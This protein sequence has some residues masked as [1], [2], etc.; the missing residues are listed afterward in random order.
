MRP[1]HV[2]FDWSGT[3][4]DDLPPVLEATNAVLR[5]AGRSAMDRETFRREFRLPYTDFYAEHTPH[6]PLPELEGV[7]RQAFA[8][9]QA[10][11]TLLPHAERFLAASASRGGRH[12][13]LSS[14]PQAA[15]E[16]QARDLG[17]YDYFEAF[18]ASVI[19]KRQRIHSL[20][21]ELGWHPAA[22]LYVGDMVHDAHTARQAGIPFAAVL[23]GYDFEPVLRAEKPDFLLEDLR[24]LLPWLELFPLLAS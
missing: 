15:V 14:A 17:I 19:D 7:F 21:Q 12:V 8:Q 1:P 20:L 16:K 13:V 24:G 4:V 3:V 18:H 6:V 2:I 22:T 5:Y 9:S 23:T 11:V 10:P